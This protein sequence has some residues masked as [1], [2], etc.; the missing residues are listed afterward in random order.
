MI[1]PNRDVGRMVTLACVFLLG[2]VSAIGCAFGEIRLDDPFQR[3]YSLE[4]ATKRYSD[5]VRWSDFNRASQFVD[6]EFRDD[7]LRNAPA[8]QEVRFTDY[9]TDPVELDEEKVVA[10]IVVRYF[11]YRLSNPIEIEIRETQ[12]WERQSGGL[13]SWF[14]RSTFEGLETDSRGSL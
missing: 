6:P 5:Y 2:G 1:C 11:A 4:E 9:K 7:F 10:T 8:F 3:K 13:N 12:E 14:V